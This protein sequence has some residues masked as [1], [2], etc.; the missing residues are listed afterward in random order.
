MTQTYQ[1]KKIDAIVQK[2]ITLSEYN[3]FLFKGSMG[4]GKTTLIN[5]FCKHLGVIDTVSSPTFS[6]VNEYKTSSQESIFHFDCY[7]LE[8]EE[9]AFDFGAEEYLDS[10]YMCLIEWP[11][12]IKS[13]LPDQVHCIELDYLDQNTRKI[14]FI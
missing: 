7:R 1:L 10:G 13:L 2:I 8:S 5:S 12:K 9:E 11:D 6:L 14:N 3:I 4:V